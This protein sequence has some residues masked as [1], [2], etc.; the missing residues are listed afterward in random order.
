MSIGQRS[1][2]SPEGDIETSTPGRGITVVD[3][4]AAGFGHAVR[5]H[6]V[7]RQRL[8]R[9]GAAEED[10]VKK[11][12]VYTPERGRYERHED[13]GTTGCGDGSGVET[14]EHDERGPGQE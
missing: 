9:L 3:D 1:A 11:A 4:T 10:L 2:T 13:L 7:G 14:V 8:G 12:C 6:D 5:R